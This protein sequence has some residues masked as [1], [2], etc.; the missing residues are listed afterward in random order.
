MTFDET[1][2]AII[3]QLK[4]QAEMLGVPVTSIE[5]GKYNI[6]PSRMPFIWAYLEAA[7]GKASESGKIGGRRARGIVC[8]GVEMKK[9]SKE[10]I[11]Q[12]L[13]L[14]ERCESALGGIKGIVFPDDPIALDSVYNGKTAHILQFTIRYNRVPS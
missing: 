4:S 10:S 9:D 12:S 8:C 1:W 7:G 5:P 2:S 3:D 6:E 11:V 14:A 13:E